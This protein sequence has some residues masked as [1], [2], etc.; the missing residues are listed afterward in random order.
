MFVKNK[1][2]MIY[3]TKKRTSYGMS[4]D[5]RLRGAKLSLLLRSVFPGAA[6]CLSFQLPFSGWLPSHGRLSGSRLSR[7][8]LAACPQPRVSSLSVSH[9]RPLSL[10]VSVSFRLRF[11]SHV[12]L[13]LYTG[14]PSPS[15]S[16]ACRPGSASR[17]CPS[18]RG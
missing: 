13:C 2:R 14:I 12:Y 10:P 7:L 17:P 11:S 15:P 18:I 1:M 3:Q 4:R 5:S 16:F 6:V 8:L 9:S